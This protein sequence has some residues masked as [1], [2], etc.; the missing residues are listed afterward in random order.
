MR[1]PFSQRR[2]ESG[3]REVSVMIEV[4]DAG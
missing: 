1:T 4:Q 2:G 3:S